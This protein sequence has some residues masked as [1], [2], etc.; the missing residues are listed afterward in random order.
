MYRV[1]KRIITKQ[2][3]IDD[4]EGDTD[5]CDITPLY[6]N[7]EGSKAER[8]AV[9]NAVRDNIFTP[10]IYTPVNKIEDVEF[11]LVDIDTVPLGDSF[12]VIVNIKNNGTETRNINAVLTADSVHYNGVKKDFI[13]REQ[14]NFSVRAGER[15]QL[16]THVTAEDYMEKLSDH[17]LIKIYAIAN[18]EETKQ[19]WSEEDDFNLYKP[20]LTVRAMGDPVVGEQFLVEF[21]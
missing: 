12:D 14:G 17:A 18:V 6:K 8:L 21:R 5:F 19:T 4:D 15:E 16:V 7:P 11:D 9:Y 2:I 13:K 10:P 1:G 20:E 3:G